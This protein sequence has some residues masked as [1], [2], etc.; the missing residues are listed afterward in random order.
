MYEALLCRL[1]LTKLPQQA[2]SLNPLIC[3]VQAA[4]HLHSQ[5]SMP[6][7]CTENLRCCKPSSPQAQTDMTVLIDKLSAFVDS[8]PI[9]QIVLL[10]FP[11][12][13]TLVWITSFLPVKPPNNFLEP[14]RWKK[15]PLLGRSAAAGPS[16]SAVQASVSDESC[17]QTRRC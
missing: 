11:V 4:K 14:E 6:P 2:H 5:P 17:V 3:Q 13:M 15:L 1:A 7:A 16:T 10:L 12:V 9:W 8:L